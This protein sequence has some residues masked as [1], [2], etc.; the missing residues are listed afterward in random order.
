MS[1]SKFLF[2][3]D[4]DDVYQEHHRWLLNWLRRK[5]GC[6]H[7]AA[8]LAHDT[9]VRLIIKPRQDSIRQPRAYLTTIAHGLLVDHF[10]RKELEQAYLEIIVNLPASDVPSPEDRFLLLE[11]L[12]QIDILLDGLPIKARSAFLMS[13]LDGL[14]H[15][16]IAKLLGISLSS[17]EKYIAMALRHCYAASLRSI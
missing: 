13:R 10:R 6:P 2:I 12:L 17:V 3:N 1:N 14:I 11:T 9:F 8:D 7:H 15:S 5:L 4:V 16:E